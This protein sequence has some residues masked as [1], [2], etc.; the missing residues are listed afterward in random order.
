MDE[1]CL[2]IHHD[3]KFV[4]LRMRHLRS[5]QDFNL[6]HLKCSHT[7]NLLWHRHFVKTQLRENKSTPEKISSNGTVSQARRC[8]R[9]SV[10][11]KQCA[12]TRQ[13][14]PIFL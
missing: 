7:G 12:K 3:G 13:L 6:E 5:Y 1:N 4:P 10:N 14:T 8:E 9:T 11:S 2:T